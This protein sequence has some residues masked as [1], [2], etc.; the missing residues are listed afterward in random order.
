LYFSGVKFLDAAYQLIL[1]RDIIDNSYS[2]NNS[3]IIII[4]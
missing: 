4:K 3:K 2:N 1:H